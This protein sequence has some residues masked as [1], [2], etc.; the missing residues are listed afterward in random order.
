MSTDFRHVIERLKRRIDEV[1]DS[2]VRDREKIMSWRTCFGDTDRGFD[3]SY[4]DS[5][6]EPLENWNNFDVPSWFRAQVTIPKRFSGMHV[7]LSLK[8]GGY[9]H[10]LFNILLSNPLQGKFLLLLIYDLKLNFNRR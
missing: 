9:L 1:G 8:I 3:V 7:S 2:V 5:E 4:D 10:S 6:W